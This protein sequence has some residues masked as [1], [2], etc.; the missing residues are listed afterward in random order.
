MA[1]ASKETKLFLLPEDLVRRL[2]SLALRQGISSTNYAAEAIEQA[3]IMEKRGAT[4][5]EAVEMYNIYEISRSAGALQIPRTNF[6]EIISRLYKE[7]KEG[8]LRAWKSAGRWYGE[9]LHAR[10]GEAV[11]GYLK[12]ALLVGWNLDEVELVD[13]EGTVEVSYTSFIMSEELTELLNGYIRGIMTAM[14]YE[15]REEDSMRGLTTQR[16]AKHRIE[17]NGRR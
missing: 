15:M 17:L 8:L 10:L 14:G 13:K 7:D 3:L 16:Y 5:Q 4:L 6:N 11:L 9:Y 1:D 12:S 2:R